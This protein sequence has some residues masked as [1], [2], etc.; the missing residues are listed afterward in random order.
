MSGSEQALHQSLAALTNGWRASLLE[1]HSCSAT[2]DVS[3]EIV[4]KAL[5]IDGLTKWRVF[6]T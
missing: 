5:R 1:T 4:Y 2:L 3:G 6:Q